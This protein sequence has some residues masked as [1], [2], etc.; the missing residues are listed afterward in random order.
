MDNLVTLHPLFLLPMAT[1]ASVLFFI[2]L[3]RSAER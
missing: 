3:D 2:W 1:F